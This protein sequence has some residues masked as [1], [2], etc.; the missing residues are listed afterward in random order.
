MWYL[1][2]RW[3]TCQIR[4][5]I[6]SKTGGRK[7]KRNIPAELQ[8]VAGQTAYVE[9]VKESSTSGLRQQGNLFAVQTDAK[10]AALRRKLTIGDAA[11]NNAGFSLSDLQAK[12]IAVTYFHDR[13]RANLADGSYV[14]PQTD[15]DYD[16]VLSDAAS[17]YEEAQ[18]PVTGEY[19]PK[20]LLALK[21]LQENALITQHLHDQIVTGKWPSGLRSHRG[22]QLLC[23]YLE[24]AEL[25]EPQY[26][27]GATLH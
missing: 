20:P 14:L 11:Q 21:I 27:A 24:Y 2:E 26:R 23:R 17:E 10:I 1:L 8:G 4:Y 22:F 25:R 7:F 12:Q 13:D 19:R 9:R 3:K 5:L 18:R 15:P 6:T 16:E